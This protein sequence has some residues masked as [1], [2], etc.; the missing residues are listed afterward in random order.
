MKEN[1]EADD[2]WS[3]VRLWFLRYDTKSSSSNMGLT[4]WA[5]W[6]LKD[7]WLQRMLL[8]KWKDKPQN[9][10]KYVQLI[11][12]PSVWYPEYKGCLYLNH[13]KTQLKTG[14]RIQR[15]IFPKK[16]DEWPISTRKYAQYCLG[17]EFNNHKEIAVPTLYEV[18]TQS[19]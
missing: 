15:N 19:W 6:K 13:N 11:N 5:S 18:C 16:I 1:T 12:L 14:Q 2:L 17:K 9:G 4:S 7:F 8:R 10:R 3:K